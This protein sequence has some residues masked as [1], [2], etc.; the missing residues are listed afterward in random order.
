MNK[1]IINIARVLSLLALSVFVGCNG[2]EP[3]PEEPI[4]EH[5]VIVYMIANNNLSSYAVQNINMMES[6]YDPTS[7][8]KVL[9]FYNSSSGNCSIM[10]LV[11]DQTS[12]IVSETLYTYPSNT[13]P[14]DPATLQDAIERCRELSDAEQYSLVLWSHATGWLP[15][16]MSPATA[17]ALDPEKTFGSC[18][19]FPGEMEIYDLADALP[20]DLTFEY[21]YFDACYMGSVEAAFEL[22]N[23][24][25]YYV[26]SVA[27]VLANGYPYDSGFQALIDGDALGVAQNFFN[28]YNSQSGVDQS[29][30]ISVVELE[31]LD[32]VAEQFAK[33]PS[34]VTPTAQ[35]QF[36]RYLG[37]SYN[38]K[39]LLWD[40][41]DMLERTWGDD[42]TSVLSAMDDA[43]VYKA[44]TPILFEGDYYGE[45][46][47][48][49][50][51][52]LSI[53][54]PKLSQPNT[55]EIY[56]NNYSWA[57]ESKFYEF[58]Y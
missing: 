19:A 44:A 16:G 10:E 31:K 57:K 40:M 17:P 37:S 54:I 26:S 35:Q 9:L 14:T 52:G 51:C 27:E 45:I 41:G 22:R 53:Y 24:A 25:K 15:D 13:D 12:T 21:I 8:N 43:I 6:A 30:T 7:G 34:G 32:A 50:F 46:T 18:Y 20:T 5:T 42:A 4:N 23:N 29:A 58:A 39:D 3:Q 36:G 2:E 11:H 56:T 1:K 55:L 49:T 38:F 28:Y 47:V 48:D 33:L